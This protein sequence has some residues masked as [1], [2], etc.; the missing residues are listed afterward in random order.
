MKRQSLK[1]VHDDPSRSFPPQTIHFEPGEL[2]QVPNIG[3]FYMSTTGLA[4]RVIQRT[5]YYGDDNTV[6]VTL[7]CN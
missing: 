1:F 2:F 6:L 7:M 3:D 4:V 5:F